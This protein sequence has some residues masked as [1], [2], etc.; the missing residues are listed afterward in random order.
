[1]VKTRQGLVLDNLPRLHLG[2]II[3]NQALA[4]LNHYLKTSS[5]H[6]DSLIT[7][8]VLLTKQLLAVKAIYVIHHIKT[9]K[10]V[11]V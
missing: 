9:Y 3:T 2:K 10:P 8:L 4:G 6:I 11:E 5:P 1:M 7:E